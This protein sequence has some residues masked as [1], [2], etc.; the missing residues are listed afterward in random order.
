MKF[1][2]VK[3]AKDA[4][5][6]PLTIWLFDNKEERDILKMWYDQVTKNIGRQAM[7]VRA[8]KGS[9]VALF[10]NDVSIKCDHKKPKKEGV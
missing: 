6:V 5:L 2:T 1:N 4:K 8:D 10:V 7:Y 9:C 3:E